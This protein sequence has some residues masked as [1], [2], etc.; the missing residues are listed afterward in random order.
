MSVGGSPG[1]TAGGIK[2]TTLALL[3]LVGWS[4][5][6]GR[7]TVN[8]ADRTVPEETIQRAVGLSLAAFAIMTLTIFMLTTSEWGWSGTFLGRMFEVVSAFGTV[9][10]SMNVTP[11][12]TGLGRLTVIV[13]MFVGRVGTLTFAAALVIRRRRGGVV[14]YAGEDVVVG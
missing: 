11:E 7:P 8:F 14:R 6:R 12:L 13:L 2:T 4:R 3:V 10:L 5:V 1:S 9:G